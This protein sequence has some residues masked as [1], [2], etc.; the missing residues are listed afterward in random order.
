MMSNLIALGILTSDSILLAADTEITAGLGMKTEGGKIYW[1]PPVDDPT[2][3]ILAVTG[4]GEVGY[5]EAAY[6]ELKNL[7]H[8]YP[9]DSILQ[10]EPRFKKLLREFYRDHVTP[11]TAGV[12]RPISAMG[13]YEGR[14]IGRQ[15][16][17]GHPRV[18]QNFVDA[19]E[20]LKELLKVGEVTVGWR[21]D[22][23]DP[24]GER[25]HCLQH[26]PLHLTTPPKSCSQ[27]RQCGQ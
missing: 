5:I 18:V 24:I 1:T 15:A 2:K 13:F 25:A 27:R 12:D 26:A 11:F 22:G 7:F 8:S 21:L 9:G 3:G 4:A 17:T 23:R 10:L 6:C 14:C 19:R 20:P 16:H